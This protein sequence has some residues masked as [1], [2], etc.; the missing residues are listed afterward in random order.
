MIV[1]YN[2]PQESLVS[3]RETKG[4]VIR[5]G[6]GS[7]DGQSVSYCAV[8]ALADAEKR[9]VCGDATRRDA[10]QRRDVECSFGSVE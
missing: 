3:V 7:A 6:S 1:Q 4:A 5:G 10:S 2:K 8:A 9:R